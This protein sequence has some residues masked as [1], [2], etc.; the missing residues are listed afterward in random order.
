LGLGGGLETVL[1]GLHRNLRGHL[2]RLRSAHAVGHHEQGRA[3][4]QRILVGA[5]LAPGV[6]RRVLLGHAEHQSTSN[7][8]SL[9]PIR[10]RS[11]GSS[12]EAEYRPV[13]SGGT[14]SAAESCSRATAP[15]R[16]RRSL[17]ALRA[18]HSANRYMTARNPNFNATDT[19]ARV[20]IELRT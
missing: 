7:A 13:A 1:E 9:S 11:P 8:N 14:A 6:A 15:A 19:G 12:V 10:T 5:P 18:T 3:R 4:Q 20:V 16:P 17:R 2:P